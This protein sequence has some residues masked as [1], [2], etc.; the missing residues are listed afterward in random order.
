[1]VDGMLVTDILKTGFEKGNINGIM[2]ER[3]HHSQVCPSL[4]LRSTCD[5]GTQVINA[6]P[7]NTPEAIDSLCAFF[8]TAPSITPFGLIWERAFQA[9]GEAT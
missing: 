2:V 8:S 6:N 1:M 5:T 4:I 7:L 3:N 9:G